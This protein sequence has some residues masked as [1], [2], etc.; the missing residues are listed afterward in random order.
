MYFVSEGETEMAS[1]G[2]FALFVI[3]SD[4]NIQ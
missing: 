1:G 3:P 2:R 4:E